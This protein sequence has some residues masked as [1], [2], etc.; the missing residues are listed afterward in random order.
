MSETPFEPGGAPEAAPD[1]Q[2]E[3][4]PSSDP[5]GASTAMPVEPSV[6]NPDADGTDG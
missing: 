5:D 4:T 2:P 1:D 3:I 6:T